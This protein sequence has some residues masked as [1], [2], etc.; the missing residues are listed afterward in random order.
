MCLCP[1][2]VLLGRARRS[3]PGRACQL[4]AEI[5]IEHGYIKAKAKRLRGAH[6]YFD[7][8]TVTGTENLMM[9]ACLADGTTILEN[10]A[11]EPEICDLADFL[12]KRGANCWRRVRCHFNRGCRKVDGADHEVIPDRIE[13][14]TYLIA[15]AITG[16]DIVVERCRPAIWKRC[17]L[18]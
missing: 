5:E 3:A 2:D 12:V 9:A 11:K 7:T 8:P 14:G 16:G 10:A 4:G 1:A 13:T 15:G 6:I 18:S 17:S